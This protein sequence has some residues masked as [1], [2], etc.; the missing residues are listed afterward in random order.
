MPGQRHKPRNLKPV[1]PNHFASSPWF[2]PQWA[3]PS[4]FLKRVHWWEIPDFHSKSS[5]AGTS[6]TKPA[7]NPLRAQDFLPDQRRSTRLVAHRPS[8][9]VTFHPRMPPNALSSL[10]KWDSGSLGEHWPQNPSNPQHAWRMPDL[11]GSGWRHGSAYVVS[12]TQQVLCRGL[13]LPC[14]PS[15]CLFPLGPPFTVATILIPALGLF[16]CPCQQPSSNLKKISR[17]LLKTHC[18]GASCRRPSSYQDSPNP[19]GSAM[20]IFFHLSFTQC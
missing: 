18:Q 3:L 16:T 13:F 1:S 2:A 19:Q 20:P 9:A 12:G 8:P 15:S 6:S 17:P 5:Q 10:L 7:S 11:A 4:L 14:P